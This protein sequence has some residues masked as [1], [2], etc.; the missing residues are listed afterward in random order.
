MNVNTNEI[1]SLRKLGYKIAEISRLTG[2]SI[3]QVSEV[4]YY[5]NT[6]DKKEN[7]D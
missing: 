7:K 4:I 2:Y 5:Q 6:L 1:L 3:S